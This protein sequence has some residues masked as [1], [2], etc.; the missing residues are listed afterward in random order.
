MS[1]RGI[2]KEGKVEERHITSGKE[3]SKGQTLRIDIPLRL[4]A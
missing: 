1:R 2:G 4:A 3:V